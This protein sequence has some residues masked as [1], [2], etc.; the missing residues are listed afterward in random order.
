LKGQEPFEKLHLNEGRGLS[1]L[2]NLP[3]FPQPVSSPSF[4]RGSAHFHTPR[5]FFGADHAEGKFLYIAIFRA[6]FPGADQP[7]AASPTAGGGKLTLRLQSL[8][9]I[10]VIC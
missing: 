1:R 4:D 7:K 6:F 10:A 5:L 8:C 3:F 2:R 9:L